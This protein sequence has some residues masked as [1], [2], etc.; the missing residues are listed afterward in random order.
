MRCEL[1]LKIC[2]DIQDPDALK[3]AVSFSCIGLLVWL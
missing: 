3:D 1:T 2:E